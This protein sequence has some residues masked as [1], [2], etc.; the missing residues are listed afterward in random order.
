MEFRILGPL[1]VSSEGQALD[2]G[3][4]KQRAL[5]AV[6]LLDPNNVWRICASPASRNATLYRLLDPFGQL[7][8]LASGEV[9]LGPVARYLGMG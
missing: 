1:E 8:A 5:L 7:S 3:G 6:L 4:A 9:S 2:L